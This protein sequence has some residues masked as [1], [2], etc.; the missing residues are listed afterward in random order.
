MALQTIQQDRQPAASYAREFEHRA[1]NAGYQRE[2]AKPLL[3]ASLNP[4]TLARLDS[5][6]TMQGGE[7]FATLETQNER[8]ARVSYRRMLIYLCTSS[9]PELVAQ[10]TDGIEARPT[11]DRHGSFLFHMMKPG[12]STPPRPGTCAPSPP[13]ASTK[14]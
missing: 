1:I 9:L 6:L 11:T 12:L 3:V 14:P 2:Q 7:E 8:L 10:G 5:Y 13:S 4:D